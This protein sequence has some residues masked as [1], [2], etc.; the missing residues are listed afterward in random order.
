M[1]G[2][3]LSFSHFCLVGYEPNKIPGE[4][5]AIARPEA[6]FYLEVLP[7]VPSSKAHGL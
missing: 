1:H 7:L 5:V 2:K 3:H 6:R 4:R